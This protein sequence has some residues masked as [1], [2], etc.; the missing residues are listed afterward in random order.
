MIEILDTIFGF[1]TRFRPR[2]ES[3]PGPLEHLVTA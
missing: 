1:T 2:S 3:A